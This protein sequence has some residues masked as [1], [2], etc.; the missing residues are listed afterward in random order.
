MKR[1]ETNVGWKN[2]IDKLLFI[3][4]SVYLIS[5]LTWFWKYHNQSSIAND[6]LMAVSVNGENN[7]TNPNS[8]QSSSPE[9][10]IS[11]SQANKPIKSSSNLGQ[12]NNSESV[13]STP[14]SLKKEVFEEIAFSGNNQNIPQLV[15]QL[16]T[17]QL[18]APLPLPSVSIPQPPPMSPP[19]SAIPIKTPP[20]PQLQRNSTPTVKVNKLP[21]LETPSQQNII[22]ANQPQN[23]S[24]SYEIKGN[25]NDGN[26]N[27]VLLGTIELENSS[28]IALFTINNLT[29][30]VEVGTEIGATGWFLV[31]IDGRKAI[32]NRQNQSLYLTVGEKF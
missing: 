7:P 11:T 29:E 15:P 14:N 13:Q 19:V 23:S 28:G 9:T 5:T 22:S 16:P 10:D 21:V 30:K 18:P 2:N 27:N 1:K 26:K 20:P 4:A 31:G 32:I 12:N 6:N 8:Q 25:D 24:P 17:P 3:I